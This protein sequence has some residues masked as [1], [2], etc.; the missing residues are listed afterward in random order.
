MK[1][2][3]KIILPG[4]KITKPVEQVPPIKEKAFII[5]GNKTAIKQETI[6]ST[7]VIEKCWIL[8]GSL[9]NLKTFNN[10]SLL[11]GC[12]DRGKHVIRLKVIAILAIIIKISFE[13]TNL[14]LYI[15]NSGVFYKKDK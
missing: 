9:F 1:I 6:T 10:N 13:S 8:F 5:S 3:W 12:I 11:I 14:G 7:T 4:K 15:T 2:K